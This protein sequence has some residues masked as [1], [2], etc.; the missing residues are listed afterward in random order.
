MNKKITVVIV[1]WNSSALLPKLTETLNA[2]EPLCD[3]VISD[4][5]STDETCEILRKTLPRVTVLNNRE[6][7]GF[8]YG[9]NRAFEVCRTPYILLLNTDARISVSAVEKLLGI[10]EKNEGVAAIQPLIRLWQWPLVTLSA[11]AA[12]TEYGRGYD[13]DFMHFKPFPPERTVEVPAVT[14][15]VSLFRREALQKAGGFDESVFMYYE[16]TDLCMRLRGGGYT[17][18]LAQSIE[19]EHMMGFSSSRVIA[20]RWELESSAYLARKYLGGEMCQLPA[21]WKK[22]EWKIRLSLLLKRKPWFW[23]IS[24]VYKA[25][26]LPVKHINLP[27][28]VLQDITAPR[29]MRMPLKRPVD[30]A[31]A[32]ST[33]NDVTLR[34]GWLDGRIDDCGFGCIQVPSRIGSLTF[35]ARPCNIS[36]SLAL[37]SVNGVI[38]RRFLRV[39]ENTGFTAAI[40]E[41][42]T[43]LYLVP[44]RRKQKVEIDNVSY[45]S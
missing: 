31:H 15:A 27:E 4:N 8:G 22:M 25:E 37:W 10:L 34:P 13:F 28:S 26:K 45:T 23:R 12:M 11:G 16:D 20:D 5:S 29:P 18:L 41:G 9:N 40:D 17:F 7:G 39:S 35:T 44:D 42:T 21:Y 38:I 3:I 6:N 1:T 19:A 2:L 24:A 43:H 36:G 14:A 33:D 30:N 32:H